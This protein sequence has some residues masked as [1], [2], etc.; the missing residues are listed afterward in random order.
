MIIEV[1]SFTKPLRTVPSV[2]MAGRV[3]G[4]IP[5]CPLTAMSDKHTFPTQVLEDGQ[6]G[7]VAGDFQREEK[8][9]VQS[10]WPD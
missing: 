9:W 7:T 5:R 2:V 6:V 8:Q 10:S 4:A 3:G 1:P